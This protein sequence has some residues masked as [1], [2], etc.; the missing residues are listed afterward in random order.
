LEWLGRAREAGWLAASWRQS[1]YADPS[2]Q[3]A[4]DPQFGPL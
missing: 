3:D 2:R 4:A 1:L